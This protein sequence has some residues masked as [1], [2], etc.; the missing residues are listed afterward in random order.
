MIGRHGREGR[1]AVVLQARLGSTR[2]PGKVLADLGGTTIL[3]RCIYRL[4]AACVGPVIVA[5]TTLAE[6]EAV[7]REARRHGAAVVRGD[8]LDVLS[9]F[10]AAADTYHL[11]WIIRATADNPFVDI[12]AP[13]R[14]RLALGAGSLDHVV[15]QGLPHGTAVEAVHVR[16]L[17][18]AARRATDPGDREHVT[19]W[20]RRQPELRVDQ[21]LAPVAV[22]RPDI[23]LTID[24]EA[25]LMWARALARVVNLD[26][27]VPLAHIIAVADGVTSRMAA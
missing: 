16:A 1:G 17:R 15:E 3:G 13:A 18:E 4:R 23:R 9:R 6:D 27:P 24:T 22:R 21:P 5:T 7:A 11:D 20:L 2:L 26:E 19:P 25:D 12:E 8:A 10:I 14:V